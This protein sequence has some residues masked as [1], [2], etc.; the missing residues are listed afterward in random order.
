MCCGFPC[1]HPLVRPGVV[2][3]QPCGWLIEVNG[4]VT[5]RT[6]S[7]SFGEFLD[8]VQLPFAFFSKSNFVRRCEVEGAASKVERWLVED[9]TDPIN[10]AIVETIAK[11][12]VVTNAVV[13]VLGADDVVVLSVVVELV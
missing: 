10:E 9:E 5:A 6:I 2:A 12:A 4:V 8:F 3:L 1:K 7:S 11:D 13:V